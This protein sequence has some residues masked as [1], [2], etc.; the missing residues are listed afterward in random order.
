MTK[1]T[2]TRPDDWHVHLRDGDVLHTTVAHTARC[3][4]RALI[5]P[6]LKPP[7]TTTAAAL[8]YRRRILE[9]LP[10][11]TA[12][13]PHMAL[14][15]TDKTPA[16][17]IATA[18]ESGHVLAVKLYPAGATTHSDQGVTQMRNVHAVLE[19][20]Q[21]HA[22]PLSIHG[23]VTDPAVDAFDREKVFIERVLAPLVKDFPAL[24]IVLEHISTREAVDYIRSAPSHVA[25]TI[26]V[27]H[28]LLN[29]NAMVVGGIQPHHYCLPVLKRE[30][31][32]QALLAAAVSGESKFFLGSDSAPHPRHAKETACGC[33][34]IYSAP[35]AIEL[36]ARVFEH[37]GALD[38][39]EGFASHHGA[40]FYDLP[41]ND[42]RI[43]LERSP[44]TIPEAYPFGE[45]NIVP[46]WAGK[47]TEWRLA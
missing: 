45:D 46:L 47:Q 27:H 12:F 37:M 20:M 9:A 26:T 19:A 11:G 8:D 34:G 4:G 43:T 6:N 10:A 18:R 1:I 2:M 25:A 38:K 44:W 41:R 32:R 17:E 5:M 3:C 13:T 22:M 30:T 15:L 21:R 14:Y 39:L 35:A 31:H 28:L 36:Y 23:E 29:R 42:Q 33:A 7:V 24:P 40:D 16:E